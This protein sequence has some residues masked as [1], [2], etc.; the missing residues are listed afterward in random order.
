MYVCVRGAGV[1]EES[2]D[3]NLTYGWESIVRGG[4]VIRPPGKVAYANT[5]KVWQTQHPW[6]QFGK[7]L[8]GVDGATRGM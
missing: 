3:I 5:V 8:S 1:K 7:G 2:G 6:C 4:S